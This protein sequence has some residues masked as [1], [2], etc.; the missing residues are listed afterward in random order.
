MHRCHSLWHEKT[1]QKRVT[2]AVKGVWVSLRGLV[3]PNVSVLSLND[4]P[5]KSLLCVWEERQREKVWRE[6]KRQKMWDEEEQ[7]MD[8][9]LGDQSPSWQSHCMRV[10]SSLWRPKDSLVTPDKSILFS[11]KELDSDVNTIQTDT[12]EEWWVRVQVRVKSVVQRKLLLRSRQN[13]ELSPLVSQNCTSRLGHSFYSRQDR[14]F[15][16]HGSRI[17]SRVDA[18]SCV[19]NLLTCKDE[20]EWLCKKSLQSS[21]FTLFMLSLFFSS[22]VSFL[23]QS[24]LTLVESLPS[25]LQWSQCLSFFLWCNNSRKLYT[26]RRK[27]M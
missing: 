2:E 16:G 10:S 13:T 9:F 19:L 3:W 25:G 8:I 18:I 7:M 17:E 20:N 15:F 4:L 14:D 12:K 23:S 6:K 24:S 11:M 5:Y 26:N 21:T 1:K 27:F 22:Q